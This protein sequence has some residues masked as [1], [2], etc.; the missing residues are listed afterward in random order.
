MKKE[1]DFK[2]QNQSSPSEIKVERLGVFSRKGRGSQHLPPN[3]F[4]IKRQIFLEERTQPVDIWLMVTKTGQRS[5]Y[6]Y[7][8]VIVTSVYLCGPPDF[9]DLKR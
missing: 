2:K 6:T 4:S 8:K 1:H 9:K 7:Q 3:A 5:M